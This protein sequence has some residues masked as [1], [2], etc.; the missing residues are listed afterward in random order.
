MAKA[1]NPSTTT[2]S[3]FHNA[4]QALADMLRLVE[5]GLS[6]CGKT[7]PDPKTWRVTRD[8]DVILPNRRIELRARS[9]SRHTAAA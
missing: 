2:R 1:T 7:T 3:R 9:T 5:A 6:G 4:S 8:G